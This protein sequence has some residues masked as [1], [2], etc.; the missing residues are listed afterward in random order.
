MTGVGFSKQFWGDEF[1]SSIFYK[2]H[3]LLLSDFFYI[4]FSG[5]E[6]KLSEGVPV[7]VLPFVIIYNSIPCNFK[8]KPALLSGFTKLCSSCLGA[9]RES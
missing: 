1:S 9:D 6:I 3:Y 2:K 4:C 7:E 8:N 5:R